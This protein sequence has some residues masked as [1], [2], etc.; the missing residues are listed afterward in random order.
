M[1]REKKDHALPKKL[2]LFVAAHPAGQNQ[3]LRAEL[4]GKTLCHKSLVPDASQNEGD[5]GNLF[6]HPA[7]D[8]RHLPHSLSFRKNTQIQHLLVLMPPFPEILLHHLR[9]QNTVV[10]NDHNFLLR[11][12]HRQDLPPVLRQYN[13]PAALP[14]GFPHQPLLPFRRILIKFR[15]SRSVNVID[16][17]NP[18]SGCHL[19]ER[20]L[21]E[22]AR[23]ERRMNMNKFRRI[24]A[25]DLP[26][27]P[28]CLQ[29]FFQFIRL[30]PVAVGLHIR[31]PAVPLQT[32]SVIP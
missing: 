29:C 1:R 10:G 23:P 24:L 27:L 28:I 12:G 18:F 32:A 15:K 13:H 11:K 4:P 7:D 21:A 9:M 16:H 5:I 6:C 22:E 3:I 17:R 26:E 30:A 31:N 25:Q 8:L 2:L 14:I 20:E 19:N